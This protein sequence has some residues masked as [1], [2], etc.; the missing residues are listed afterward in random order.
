M[1]GWN[2]LTPG[3]PFTE[4]RA[5]GVRKAMVLMTDGTNN[6]SRLPTA[7]TKARMLLRRTGRC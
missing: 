2:V 3:P 4:A 5:S 1:W 7:P 6:V